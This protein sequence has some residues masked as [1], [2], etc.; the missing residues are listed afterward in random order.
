MIRSLIQWIRVSTIAWLVFIAAAV[1]GLYTVKYRVL[2]LQREIASV[3]Q[4]LK[5]EQQN[6]HVVNAEWAYLTRPDRLQKL[7]A[8]NTKLMPVQ[9]V[10]VMEVSTLPFPIATNSEQLANAPVAKGISPVSARSAAP[11]I[12]E[13]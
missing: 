3:E 8:A 5:Q 7:V 11:A 12:P 4:E 9:G 2:A 6:L 10:Q 1:Y 13:D